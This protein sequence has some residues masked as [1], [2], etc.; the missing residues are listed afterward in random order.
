MTAHTPATPQEQAVV[1]FAQQQLEQARANH[2]AQH[3][4]PAPIPTVADVL[5]RLRAV[6]S[7]APLY[8]RL[9]A[10]KA[11]GRMRSMPAYRQRVAQALHDRECQGGM[12]YA[13]RAPGESPVGVPCVVC[14]RTQREAALRTQLEASGVAERYLDSEW[15][16]LRLLPPLDRVEQKCRDIGA[17]L[18]SGVNLLL[19]SNE[20]GSGKTQAAM[21]AGKA[22]IRIGRTV[23]VVNLARLAL[24]VRERFDN[25][26]G[27][28]LS[29]KA[30]LLRM[31]TPDLLIIDDLG[32]GE[33]ETAAIE[34]RL[35]FLALDYRQA[36]RKAVIVTSNLPLFP[37]FKGSKDPC[38]AGIFGARV[39]ARLQPLTVLHVNHGVNFRDEK[40]EVS[41]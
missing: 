20:T 14:Q 13:E 4:R 5:G 22:A 12:I 34:R 9:S 8:P 33:G 1:N 26:T 23:A 39:T 7:T 29:E 2:A 31:T 38:L 28:A 17:L 10:V 36:H 21:L 16:G 15:S 24:D 18:D 6:P 32:A 35:L 19:H 27:E 37:L 11:L 30:A 25:K 41:W 3:P 40:T